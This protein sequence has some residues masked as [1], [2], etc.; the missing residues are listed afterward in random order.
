MELQILTSKKGTR[1][2]RSSELHRALGLN[3]NHYQTNV[4][5][6]IRDVYEFRD[7][8][9]K[10]QAMRDF[11]GDPRSKGKV[12]REYYLNLE[13]AKLVALNS[14]SKVKQAIATKLSKEA[15]AFPEDVQLSTTDTLALLE[16]VKALARI[17][18]Q[19]A[20]ET[21]HL[22]HYTRRRGSADYWNHYRRENIVG[23]TRADLKEQLEIRDITVS[24]KS[25]LRD[26]VAL[27]DPYDL[28]RIGVI[29]HYAALGN[30]LPYCQQ[31]GNLAKELAR[32]LRLEIVDDR[33]G[34]LL[35]APPANDEVVRKM[36]R[37]AA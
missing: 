21:R 32:Q 36:Q 29:D 24:A 6:W 9:R 26:L 34:E 8:I 2:V 27:F 10:P 16:Q 31:M 30:S 14:K 25:E 28:F 3:D 33:Q 19:K 12:V 11:A 22:A 23:C 17:S 15:D 4:R 5:Q 37:V 13:L 1:V 35:F 18:C 7:G 20:A